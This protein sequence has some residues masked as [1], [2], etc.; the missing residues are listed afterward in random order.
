MAKSI[1]ISEEEIEIL[2]KEAKLSSRSLAGQVTHWLRIG[3]AI[4]RAPDFSYVR[5]REAL[6]ARRSP[7]LLSSEEQ[8][9]F[10]DELM[11]AASNET[12]EQAD[13]FRQRRKAGK[14]VGADRT[15]KI[16]RQTKSSRA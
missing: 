16:V 8:A 11:Q 12:P 14:G 13:F 6:E 10:I 7:D 15:G 2:R 3:R 4:E 9:I 1:K 5:V